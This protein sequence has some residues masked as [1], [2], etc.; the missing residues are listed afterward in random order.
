MKIIIPDIVPGRRLVTAGAV[1]LSGAVFSFASTA[2][3][4]ENGVLNSMLGVFGIQSNKDQDAVDYHARA[5]LVVP[6]RNDLPPPKE[7]VRD[8]AWPNDP[9]IARERKAALE[10]RTPVRSA[11]AQGDQSA[12]N[13]GS[14]LP[15][16]GPPDD[17]QGQGFGICLNAPLKAVKSIMT[18]F[19]SSDTVQPGQEPARR[20]LT[21]PPPG[22]RKA[23]AVAKATADPPKKD[24]KPEDTDAAKYIRSP[25]R[26]LPVDN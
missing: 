12:A 24:N 18:G 13:G 1:L 15:S 23:T 10:S 8:P 25:E 2:Q 11:N 7:A 20:Y 16:D 14:L 6:P 26:K 5:P 4:Q 21:D 9:D 22:Y 17:C 19:G 3:A